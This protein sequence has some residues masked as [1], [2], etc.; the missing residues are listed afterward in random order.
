MAKVS[1]ARVFLLTGVMA[2][3]KS[4]VAEALAGRF[5]R[6]A[7]VR[8]DA[9]RTAIVS[10]RAPILPSLS[11]EAQAQ[12]A[13]RRRLGAD[14]A[15]AYHEAGFTTVL[16]DIY[17][18]EHLIEVAERLAATPLHVVVL[19]PSARVFAERERARAKTGYGDWG[20]EALWAQ[21]MDTTPRLGLWLDTSALD[22]DETV[23]AILE[24]LESSRVTVGD[25]A[26]ARRALEKS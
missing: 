13:L 25:L 4:T 2:A 17:L 24:D 16:Q 23:E 14:A 5:A 19:C 12:L 21:F 18:G 15:R 22:V 20:V 7:H 11:P 3:G 10:G 8:G 1:D 26:R 9:F 6:S